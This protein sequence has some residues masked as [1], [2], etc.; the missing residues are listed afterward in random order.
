MI[1]IQTKAARGPAGTGGASSTQAEAGPDPKPLSPRQ[2]FGFA[3]KL[4]G[5]AGLIV[6][7]IWLLDRA[8]S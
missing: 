7:V 5:I 2:D 4:F 3:V 8:V 1:N 6:L